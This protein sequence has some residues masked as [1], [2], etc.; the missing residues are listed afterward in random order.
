MLEPLYA[1]LHVR[2]LLT[3]PLAILDV[4]L[5]AVVIYQLL[6]LVRGTRSANMMIALSA[7]VLFH[8]IT[9]PGLLS[10]NAF[11]TVLGTLLGYV[12]IAVIV[13][14]QRQ[15]RQ[16]LSNLGRNPFASLLPGKEQTG[17]VE[18]V[19]LA[20][21]SLAS[22]RLGALI[23]L[24]RD[25]GLRSFYETGIS[26]DA[27]ISYDLLMNIFTYHSP[28]HDGAV[29]IAEGRIKA[30]SCYL[31]LTMNPA[32]SRTYGTRHRAAFGIT[33]ESDAL[34][35][36]VSEERGVISLV[37]GGEIVEHLDA[38]SLQ[39]ALIEALGDVKEEPRDP[40]ATATALTAESADG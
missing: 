33:E 31:P 40:R 22:K 17:M 9:R 28:L 8:L 26:L 2:E 37:D 27:E 11:H 19:A 39:N 10:L 23:V 32:L 3:S 4:L 20:A 24:E 16:A 6:L 18:E 14:F 38:A 34:A 13:L 21:A 5:L 15:I 12:P 35:V 7:L 36:I 1:A 25:M 29:V 30:A